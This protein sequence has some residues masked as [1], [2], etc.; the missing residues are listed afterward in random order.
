[1]TF[2]S[3]RFI[4]KVHEKCSKNTLKTSPNPPGL[5]P[6]SLPKKQR[7]KT[8]GKWIYETDRDFELGLPSGGF[9]GGVA[10]S[11]FDSSSS[12]DVTGTPLDRPWGP[13][14]PPDLPMSLR[15]LLGLAFSIAF[16]L[17]LI[18]FSIVFILL[19]YTSW[20]SASDCK[21]PLL[22]KSYMPI[23]VYIYIYANTC[24]HMCILK[25]ICTHMCIY[26]RR[27]SNAKPTNT[28]T[29]KQTDEEPNIHS[30]LGYLG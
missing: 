21:C 19:E 13:K 12:P 30:K 8:I 28:Q 15:D 18:P 17:F 9:G 22:S 24:L 3:F 6:G 7:K 11:V 23:Y 26:I 14:W 2:H 25:I 5:R 27:E 10:R 1:M 4:S 16:T 29:H 20:I